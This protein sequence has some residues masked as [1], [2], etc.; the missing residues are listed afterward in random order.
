MAER[1]EVML[2]GDISN[3]PAPICAIDWRVLMQPK[4]EIKDWLSLL[5]LLAP[6]KIG[7]TDRV[8]KAFPLR[9]GAKE[10]LERCWETRFCVVIVGERGTMK[11]IV[12]EVLN[13][14][15]ADGAYFESLTELRRWLETTP[16]VYRCYTNDTGWL[17]VFDDTVRVHSGW[18]EKP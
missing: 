6:G 2:R 10:W 1:G 15:I 14:Y 17:S 12:R 9:K 4:D 13:K 11:V 5:N 18:N 3:Q 8:E 16:E 7:F